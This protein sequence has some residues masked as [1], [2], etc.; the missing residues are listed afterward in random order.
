MRILPATVSDRDNPST[1]LRID[2]RIDTRST[3]APADVSPERRAALERE[4]DRVQT[5]L[6]AERAGFIP[7]LGALLITQGLFLIAFCLLLTAPAALG[8]DVR[9]L[10]ASVASAGA[11]ATLLV[12]LLLR[13]MREAVAALANQRRDLEAKLYKDF[14]R[15]PT[16]APR[17][18]LTRSLAGLAA[19]TLPLLF[20]GAWIALAVFAFA[21]PPRAAA[22]EAATSLPA[23][24]RAR[25]RVAPAPVR[26]TEAAAVPISTAPATARPITDDIY[27]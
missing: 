4:L 6:L 17:G 15:R 9:L 7:L 22:A 20:I 14:R 1:T 3:P 21:T 19:T 11:I 26:G 10:M 13:P 12:W 23:A 24:P 16:F 27:R 2:T 5:A 25:P 8:P 18:L